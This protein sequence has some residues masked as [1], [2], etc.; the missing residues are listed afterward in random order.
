MEHYL[1]FAMQLAK[2]AEKI[3]LKYFDQDVE[4]TWKEDHSPVTKADIEINDL[5]IDRVNKQY[6]EHSIYG[7]ERNLLKNNSKYIWV[8]DPID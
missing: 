2:D 7:E 8:C 1:E 3:A 4:S 5:V 6:P